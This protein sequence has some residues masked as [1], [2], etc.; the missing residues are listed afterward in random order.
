PRPFVPADYLVKRAGQLG[1][2]VVE[3]RRA[4]FVPLPDAQEGR[5]ASAAA[6][7][8]EAALVT[9]GRFALQDGMTVTPR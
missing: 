1:V 2:F 9:D 4:R 7:P 5:P 8:A 6:L 3:A